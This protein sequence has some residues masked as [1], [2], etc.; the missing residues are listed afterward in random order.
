MFIPFLYR[1][2]RTYSINQTTYM[3][4]NIMLTRW[5]TRMVVAAAAFSA[6]GT[7]AQTITVVENR[8]KKL[9]AY[10]IAGH[11]S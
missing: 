7:F 9:H 8:N 10:F 3:Q 11:N 6:I 1:T 2:I 4:R 5:L